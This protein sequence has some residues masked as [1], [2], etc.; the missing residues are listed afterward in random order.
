MHV[1]KGPKSKA[2][3]QVKM[4]QPLC[5]A[6]SYDLP[7]ASY[8]QCKAALKLRSIRKYSTACFKA[9]SPNDASLLVD[10]HQLAALAF[11]QGTCVMHGFEQSLYADLRLA[12]SSLQ[13]ESCIPTSPEVG[14]PSLRDC[15]F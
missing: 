10:G 12:A 13:S 14:A 8:R 7:T 3:Q 2:D 15:S 6:H 5:Q 1:L 11:T 4:G 9:T